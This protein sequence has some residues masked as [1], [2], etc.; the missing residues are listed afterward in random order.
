MEQDQL[1]AFLQT[2][3]TETEKNNITTMKEMIHYL[4][5][6]MQKA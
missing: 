2:I 5:N 4:A 1:K 3:I 6:Q